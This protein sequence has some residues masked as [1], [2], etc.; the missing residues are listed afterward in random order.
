[1]RTAYH[2]DA[3]G[4]AVCV[5][6]HYLA[7]PDKG[8]EEQRER[9]WHDAG[10]IWWRMA[11]RLAQRHGFQSV[12]AAGRS[13]GWLYTCPL[14]DD[15]YPAA[16]LEE[17]KALHGRASDIYTEI[18]DNILEAEA[19]E[20]MAEALPARLAYALALCLPIVDRMRGASGGDD[21]LTA[22]EARRALE[23]YEKAMIVVER[24]RDLTGEE[25]AAL[26][27]I[28]EAKP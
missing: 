25:R 3:G 14:P 13:G 22:A 21:D 28:E 24:S 15:D 2:R 26:A 9:A 10:A 19:A 16:F 11:E 23:D 6:A 17:L 4:L 1:M 7:V 12:Y 27:R 8:T 18:L 20:A 5:K